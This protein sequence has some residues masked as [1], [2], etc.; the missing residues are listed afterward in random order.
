[1]PATLAGSGFGEDTMNIRLGT[2]LSDFDTKATLTGPAGNGVQVNLEDKLGLDPD[3]QTFRGELTWRFAPR[4]RLMLGYYRFDRS[5]IGT[6]QQDFVWEF[7]DRTLEFTLGTTIET[8]FD[9]QLVPVSYA[10]SFYKS[11]DLE[12]AGQLGFHWFDLQVGVAGDAF[13]DGAPVA[14]FARGDSK[15]SGPLPV[16]GL[17]ADYALTQK[18][19]IGGHLQYFGLDY[20]D[21]S[22]NLTDARIL[23]EYRITDNINVGLGYSWYDINVTKRSGRGYAAAVDYVYNGLKA[24]IGYRF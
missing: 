14:S 3:Q 22:G 10:Y 5:S 15:V 13:V 2:F 1:V 19:L 4:H 23:A 24:F 7:P 17:H 9:W 8:T 16:I 11:D 20:D 6:A 12:F 18:W 21:Y